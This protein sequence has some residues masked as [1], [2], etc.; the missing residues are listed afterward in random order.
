MD[1]KILKALV[2]CPLFK[3]FMPDEVELILSDTSY[4]IVEFSAKDIY[5]LAGMPCKYAD[6]IVEGEMIAR[7]VGLSS[8]LVQIDRLRKSTLIAPAFIFSPHNAMPVSVET[9]CV[10]RV[11][12]L[13]PAALKHLIDSNEQIRMN[14]IQLLSTI[15]VFLSQKLR[16]LSL[17]TV[18]EK[19]AYFLI[20]AARCAC[21]PRG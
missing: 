7:M 3:G 13:L 10:T 8:K 16:V 4:R 5:T 6:I 9:S 20:K 15:D 1:V 2:A 17:F 19:V 12:R 11:L 21:L 14:F 18:R